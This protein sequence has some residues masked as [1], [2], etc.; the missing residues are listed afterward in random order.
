MRAISNALIM[1]ILIIIAIILIALVMKGLGIDPF[2][3]LMKSLKP[4][5]N[6]TKHTIQTFNQTISE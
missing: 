4:V 5:Y 6:Q 3:F 1:V 2:T